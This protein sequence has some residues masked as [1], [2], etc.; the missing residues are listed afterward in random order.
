MDAESKI[1]RKRA[2]TPAQVHDLKAMESII[3]GDEKSIFGDKNYRRK[4]DKKTA[5]EL[6]IYYGVLDKKSRGTKLSNRQLAR[7]KKKSRVRIAVEHPFAF[8]RKKLKVTVLGARNKMRN[9]LRFDM[10]CIVYNVLR[11]SFLLKKRQSPK[12][13]C[14]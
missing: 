3:S 4:A 14:A 8:M 10:W 5:R 6:G 9:A 12:P 13:I 2:F 7:N 11:T 1:I